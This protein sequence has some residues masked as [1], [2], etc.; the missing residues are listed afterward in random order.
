MT[1]EI[2]L[3]HDLLSRLRWPIFGDLPDVQV[4]D[5]AGDT[6]S[7]LRP[8]EGH[9]IASKLVTTILIKRMT[10]FND[11]LEVIAENDERDDECRYHPPESQEIEGSNGGYITIKDFVMQVGTHF[12]AHRTAIIQMEQFSGKDISE[13]TL[14]YYDG[15]IDPSQDDVMEEGYIPHFQICTF[16]PDKHES[17]EEFWEREAESC[18]RYTLTK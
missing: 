18:N 8:F 15:S 1:S 2:V 4:M 9:E 14:Y 11:V 3:D 7:T 17:A 10:I 6:S 5:D 16:R 13:D 12:K